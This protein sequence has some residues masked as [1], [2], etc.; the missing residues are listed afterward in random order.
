MGKLVSKNNSW[1]CTKCLTFEYYV[2]LH[3]KTKNRHSVAIVYRLYTDLMTTTIKLL[4]LNIVCNVPAT[5]IIMT[6]NNH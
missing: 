1:Y 2:T 3:I 4:I 5:A 6:L